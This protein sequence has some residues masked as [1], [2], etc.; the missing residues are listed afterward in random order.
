MSTQNFKPEDD[1]SDCSRRN[2]RSMRNN[3]TP[4]QPITQSRQRGAQ[5]TPAHLHW[6]GA[7]PPSSWPTQAASSRVDALKQ[8]SHFRHFPAVSTERTICDIGH[9]CSL[10]IADQIQ[11]SE[12]CFHYC[13]ERNNIVNFFETLMVQSFILTEVSFCGLLI[14]VTSSTF[15]KR[16][17]MLKEK[18]S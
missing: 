9:I 18:S 13:S 2:E 12:D 1:Q 4:Q 6:C 7:Y 5:T 14:V 11:W 16:K 3:Q 10:R 15:L 17:D 8:D